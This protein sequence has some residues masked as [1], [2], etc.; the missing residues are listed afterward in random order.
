MR[1]LLIPMTALL[2]AASLVIAVPAFADDGIE[3]EA[4]TWLPDIALSSELEVSPFVSGELAD[5]DGVPFDSGVQI[6]LLVWPSKEAQNA[7]PTGG[8]LRLE[9]VAKA[10]TG[11]EGSF[12]LK[13]QDVD[14]LAQYASEDG[15]VDFRLKSTSGDDAVVWEFSQN[16]LE[17]DGH[18]ELVP[19]TYDVD[20]S[21]AKRGSTDATEG[22]VGV[23]LKALDNENRPAGDTQSRG[24]FGVP[25]G[26]PEGPY[27][28][29]EYRSATYPDI[30]ATVGVTILDVTATRGEFV[31]TTGSRS[32]LGSAVS[33][34]GQVGTYEAGSITRI[35]TTGRD[36]GSGMLAGKATW[37]NTTEFTYKKWVTKCFPSGGT[38]DHEFSYVAEVVVRAAE[39]EGGS[40][41]VAATAP[42]LPSLG[43]CNRM[44]PQAWERLTTGNATTFSTG[45]STAGLIGL[46]LSAQAGYST[47]SSIYL[48]NTSAVTT[49]RICGQNSLDSSSAGR[50][51]MFQQ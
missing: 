45:A 44:A 23:Q 30:S 20:A 25:P 15:I 32:E 36:S 13:I 50:I 4:T 16:F 42:D 27:S 8:S 26:F 37:R 29:D 47:T 43:H 51:G 35:S 6:E 34:T 21:S 48:Q 2:C 3:E 28:C 22:M 10:L 19:G 49:K 9:P 14:A 17:V 33:F 12:S 24:G 41:R 1:R 7:V 40:D 18:L 39:H 11:D 38:I 46:N 31:F 5:S